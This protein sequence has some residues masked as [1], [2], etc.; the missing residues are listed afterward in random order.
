MLKL[1]RDAVGFFVTPQPPSGGCVLKHGDNDSY[2]ANSPQPP[3]GGCVLKL[4]GCAHFRVGLLKQP[5]S[6]GCV[7]KR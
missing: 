2:G 3:S 6:G 5:P 4:T 7:L 1:S